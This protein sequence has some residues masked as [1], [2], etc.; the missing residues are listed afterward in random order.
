MADWNEDEAERWPVKYPL[1]RPPHTTRGRFKGRKAGRW[2]GTRRVD[3]GEV[4]QRLLW[5][6]LAV[7]IGMALA[8]ACVLP[9]VFL[10]LPVQEEGVI[11]AIL[12]EVGRLLGLSSQA[13]C[14]LIGLPIP[15]LCLVMGLSLWLYRRLGR[16]KR[17]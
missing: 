6:L 13:S 16:S 10:E 1:E 17:A 7:E 11:G 4:Q 15:V 3:T 2:A 9:L 5:L 8:A 14:L 12:G